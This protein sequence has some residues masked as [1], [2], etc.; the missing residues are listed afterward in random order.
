MFGI[1]AVAFLGLQIPVSTTPFWAPKGV[2]D[3][4]DS[5]VAFRGTFYNKSSR[6]QLKIVGASEYLVWFDGKLIHDGLKPFLPAEHR[7]PKIVLPR[8]GALRWAHGRIAQ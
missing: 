5:F 3:D 4:A 2:A 1:L 8:F 7:A 6:V